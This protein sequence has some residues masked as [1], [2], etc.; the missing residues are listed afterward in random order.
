MKEK[1]QKMHVLDAI[2]KKHIDKNEHGYAN[3]LICLEKELNNKSGKSGNEQIIIAEKLNQEESDKYDFN[4]LFKE[5][6][7]I[8]DGPF[9]DFQTINDICGK[10]YTL[11]N[12]IGINFSKKDNKNAVYEKLS[13]SCMEKALICSKKI[14]DPMVMYLEHAISWA[15]PIKKDISKEI[16]RCYDAFVIT[17]SKESDTNFEYVSVWLSSIMSDSKKSKLLNL[18]ETLINLKKELAPQAIDLYRK[19]VIDYGLKGDISGAELEYVKEE[20][21][22]IGVDC[23]SRIED[24][25]VLCYENSIKHYLSEAKDYIKNMFNGNDSPCEVMEN[26]EFELKKAKE[27]AK[28]VK[29]DISNDINKITNGAYKKYVHWSLGC[30]EYMVHSN[31]AGAPFESIKENILTIKEDIKKIKENFNY[32]REI[33]EI[34][35]N[36]Y[37]MYFYNEIATAL[38]HDLGKNGSFQLAEEISGCCKEKKDMELIISCT[39]ELYA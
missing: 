33:N 17:A 27:C 23:S 31:D 10:L 20:S 32:T 19:N 26:F 3:T 1:N 35:Q 13:D 15:K 7:N 34:E 30:L 36:V 25:E 18:P 39:K 2:V 12:K 5:L 28:K 16:Q 8:D 4:Q 29:K 9:T 37:S 38:K 24:T 21:D 11:S 14:F 6:K 22:L